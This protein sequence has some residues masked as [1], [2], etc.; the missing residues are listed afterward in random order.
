MAVLLAGC[1]PPP[2]EKEDTRI[3]FDSLVKSNRYVVTV[4]NGTL[5]GDGRE[6]LL[7]ASAGAQFVG[8]AEEHNLA[9]LNEFT[10]ALFE[11]LNQAHGFQHLVL[12]TG[13]VAASIL[14]DDTRRG[15]LDQITEFVSTYPKAATFATDQEFELI[16]RVSRLSSASR[17]VWG[18]D[19]EFGGLHIL[20]RLV[21]LAPSDAARN[22]LDSL[23][24][25]A[26]HSESSRSADGDFIKNLDHRPELEQLRKFFSAEPEGEATRLVETLLISNEIYGYYKR[27]AD[28][29]VVGYWNNQVREQHMKSQFMKHYR[30]AAASADSLP[31]GILKLGHWH[32]FRGVYRAEIPT[33]GNFVTEFATSNGMDT[34]FLWT[35]VFNSRDEWRGANSD[36]V[37]APYAERGGL[38][39]LDL[40]PLRPLLY[41]D[42]ISGV[43]SS[44]RELIF[45][46]TD[47]LLLLDGAGD[48][49]YTR[50]NSGD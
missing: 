25:A 20:H 21:E 4:E 22:H 38:A 17:P 24:V 48:G 16:A 29:E 26:T 15:D 47:A 8:I 13:E 49:D 35:V 12:E 34:F 19:Q 1:S 10:G 36:S 42:L 9:E 40:R 30:M 46:G 14:T 37:F 23:I 3:S 11:A 5:A 31:R 44:V 2:P 27:A 50:V 45:Y 32:I 7:E 39:I 6:F 33:F 18:V 43:P 41:A 28:G